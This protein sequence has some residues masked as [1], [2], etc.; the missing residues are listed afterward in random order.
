M[1][2]NKI[3]SIFLLII[4]LFTACTPAPAHTQT[5]TITPIPT[6]TPSP[7]PEP[8]AAIRPSA[9]PMHVLTEG[10][11]TLPIRDISQFEY[12]PCYV[13]SE[14]R[15]HAGDGINLPKNKAPFIVYS[16][17][18]GIIDAANFVNESV[19][20][21]INIRTP[22]Y[23]D[24][25]QVY[26]DIVHVSGLADDLKIGSKIEKGQQ[27]AIMDRPCGDPR[28]GYLIDIALRLGSHKQA[29]PIYDNWTGTEYLSFFSYVEDDLLLLDDESYSIAPTCLGVSIP[30]EKRKTKSQ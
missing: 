15:F 29:N 24:N 19:G 4:A 10:D 30:S 25:K 2:T 18:D 21:E 9:T 16:P 26:I 28:G 1:K 6:S 3:C 13:F 12:V 27:L 14:D 22:F 23:L 20:W 8:T 11:V 5:P 7:T 17:S